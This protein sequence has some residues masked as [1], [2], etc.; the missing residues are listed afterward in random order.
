MSNNILVRSWVELKER[1]LHKF[2]NFH[3]CSFVAAPVTIVRSREH[4]HDVPIMRPIVPVH[5]KLMRSC[6]KLQIVWMIELLADILTKR[7]TSTSWR[8]TPTTPIIRIRPKE[9]TY[10]TF[11]WHFHNPIELVD[12]VK[13]IDW[14]WKT[15]MQAEDIALNDCS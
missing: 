9:I 8:N 10:W 2:V 1:V 3:D 6:Y 14:W 12:L 5:Y 7:V 15:S 11:S 13:S 4:R